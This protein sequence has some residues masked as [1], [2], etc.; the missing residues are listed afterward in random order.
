MARIFRQR[1]ADLPRF[2]R[3][4]RSPDELLARLHFTRPP[5]DLDVI[6]AA[7]TTAALNANP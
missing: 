2:L 5:K 6:T 3:E 4:S 1:Y 7:L